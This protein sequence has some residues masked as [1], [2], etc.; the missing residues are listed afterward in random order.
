MREAV[1][2]LTKAPSAGVKT[3]IAKVKGS[4]F[5]RELYASFLTQISEKLGGRECFVYVW[6]TEGIAEVREFVDAKE[7][8]VQAGGDLGE[9]MMNAV[10]H[11]LKQGYD[12]A[13][14]IGGDSPTMPESHI[15]DAF[16]LLEAKDVVLGP[17][18]D[19]GFCLIA[20]RIRLTRGV[21]EGIAWGTEGVLEKTKDNLDS[22]GISYGL[23]SSWHDIDTIEDLRRSGYESNEVEDVS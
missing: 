18:D 17:A 11:V 21:F 23:T 6:P 14:L 19:G 8:R 10:N 15:D 9:R 16:K 13:V 4:R 1:I 22:Q 5:A 20:S 3:R 12:K 7:Y 2:L